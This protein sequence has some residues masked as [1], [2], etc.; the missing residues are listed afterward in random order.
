MVQLNSTKF[1]G[2]LYHR[3]FWWNYLSIWHLVLLL[4]ST[5]YS[6][7]TG[8]RQRFDSRRSNNDDPFPFSFSYTNVYTSRKT[9]VLPTIIHSLIVT[10]YCKLSSCA[11]IQIEVVY[12]ISISKYFLKVDLFE[13]TNRWKI[14]SRLLLST[15]VYFQLELSDIVLLYC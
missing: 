15:N 1:A 9:D 4:A 11:L 14:D 3:I 10:C 2:N 8:L 6:C 7:L 5:E 12:I 13:N